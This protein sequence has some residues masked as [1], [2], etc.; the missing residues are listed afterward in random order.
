MGAT[1]P[2]SFTEQFV[3]PT[4]FIAESKESVEQAKKQEK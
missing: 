3:F 2:H 1:I 4:V